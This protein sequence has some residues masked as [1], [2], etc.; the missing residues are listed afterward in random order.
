MSVSLLEVVEAGGFD[1]STLEDAE[2]LVSKQNEFEEL[3]EA[4][5]ELL[6]EEES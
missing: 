4:A 2:W 5:Q 6:E 1:L 3:L